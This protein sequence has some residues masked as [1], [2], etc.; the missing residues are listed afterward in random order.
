MSKK[1]K[2]P[3]AKSKQTE[4]FDFDPI[5]GKYFFYIIP[6]LVVVYYL[7]STISTGFYQ[8]EEYGHFFSMLRFWD[9]PA[10]ILGNWD[11]PGYKILYVVPSL[12]G[13]QF[14]LFINSLLTAFTAYMV[15]QIGKQL[16]IKNSSIIAVLFAFQPFILQFSFRCYAE[17]LSGLLVLLTLFFYYKKNYLLTAFFSTWT[18]AVRQE[19]ALISMILGAIFLIPLY[20]KLFDKNNAEIQ[21][22]PVS[23][24]LIYNLLPFFILGLSPVLINVFGYLAYGNPM[25]LITNMKSIGLDMLMPKKGFFHYP[26]M[27]IFIIGPLS[28]G[29]F[30][31]GY[32]GFLRKKDALKDYFGKYGML[33]TIFTIYFAIQVLMAWDYINVGANP[34]TLRYLIPVSPLVALIGGIGLEYIIKGDSKKYIYAILGAAVIITLAFLSYKTDKTIMLSDKEYF[35]FAIMLILFSIV[36]FRIELKMNQK[37]LLS[38]VV[39]LA[40][41]FTLIDEKPMKL[42]PERLTIQEAANWWKSNGYDKRVTMMNHTYFYFSIG[43]YAKQKHPEKYYDIVKANLQKVPVGTIVLWDSHYNNRP[44]YHLD[45]PQEFFDNNP[46]FKFLEQFVSSNRRFGIMAFEKIKEY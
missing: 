17:M 32:F 28:F 36:L 30:L 27:F 46:N 18:F 40:L 1:S 41:G 5:V 11:K 15:Y 31:V 3:Q 26:G 29:L 43:E 19:F 44:E 35:K 9:D 37:I 24:Y 34:G 33:F 7:Y 38:L 14:V 6:I 4:I 2:Q 8:D 42:D 16:K 10:A 23:Y 20:K 12:L 13:Y 21:S 25:Y 22:K 39:V 45:V